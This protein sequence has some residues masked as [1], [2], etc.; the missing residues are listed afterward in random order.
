MTVACDVSEHQGIPADDRYPH[1]WLI[2]RVLF[3]GGYTDRLAG[4]NLAWAKS[5]KARGRIDGFTAYVVWL[6]GHNGSIL[7]GLDRLGVPKDCHVMIDVESWSGESYAISGNHSTE[8]N[9]L[10]DALASRQGSRSRVW[11]YANRGDYGALWPSRPAWLGL[12][13]A[14]YG[15]SRPT[16][17]NLVGWQYTNG[18][19]Q[20][21]GLP[22]ASAPWG[23]CD[24]NDL[25]LTEGDDVSAADVWSYPIKN[26][27]TGAVMTAAE[28]LLDAESKASDAEAKAGALKAQ[29]AALSAAVA[30]IQAGGGPV[31]TQFTGT[32]N[33]KAAP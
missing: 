12:V 9:A 6:P 24:H 26:P 15:G 10:A 11:G 19:Y 27:A 1:R 7:A 5:A 30:K 18:Q 4:Q 32:V 16:L 33:L 28:R 23:P 31:P 2:F 25:I 14:S 20:V 29:V 3:G 22:H 13:L 21:S 17:P 8:L